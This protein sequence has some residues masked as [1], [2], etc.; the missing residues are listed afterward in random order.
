MTTATTVAGSLVEGDEVRVIA[1]SD[2]QEIRLQ[3]P[4]NV[5][6]PSEAG[7]PRSSGYVIA[8]GKRLS[9]VMRQSEGGWIARTP[10]LDA[11]GHGGTMD[12]AIQNLL[13]AAAEYLEF[14]R[15]DEPEL[16]PDIAHHL[17]Y[18]LLLKVP[19]MSW[20]GS[21]SFPDAAALG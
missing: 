14:L 3:Y 5:P 1:P 2:D 8:T 13:D 11:L 12:A 15:D 7:Q 9:V 20:F 6:R 4:A 17:D 16:A 18:L 21:V 19:R 10:E